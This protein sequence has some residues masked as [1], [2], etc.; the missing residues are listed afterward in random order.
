MV[1]G[2]RPR[3]AASCACVSPSDLRAA[4]NSIGVM[5]EPVMNDIHNGSYN[6]N[7]GHDDHGVGYGFF[8][9]HLALRWQSAREAYP[10]DLRVGSSDYQW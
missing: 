7:A 10:S 3:R 6:A 8:V 4:L 5:S 1:E 9:E 2:S